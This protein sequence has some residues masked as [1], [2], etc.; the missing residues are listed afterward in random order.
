M[1]NLEKVLNAFNK[2]G[3]EERHFTGSTGYGHGD[4]G[5]EITNKIFKIVF[6]VWDIVKF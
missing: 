4:I 6:T 2:A 5:K 1:L 3:L